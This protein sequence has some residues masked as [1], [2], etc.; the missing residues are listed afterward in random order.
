MGDIDA[1][2]T[3]LQK[4]FGQEGSEYPDHADTQGAGVLA[5]RIQQ[6]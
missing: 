2:T 6:Q 5:L 1:V 4:D 3:I